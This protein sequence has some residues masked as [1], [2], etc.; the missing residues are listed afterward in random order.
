MFFE[1]KGEVRVYESLK[2]EALYVVKI[3]KG[4]CKQLGNKGR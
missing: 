4:R 3:S 1:S 2:K